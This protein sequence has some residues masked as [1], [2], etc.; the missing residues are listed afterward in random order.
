MVAK[1]WCFLLI[2]TDDTLGYT[3]G[4]PM[5]KKCSCPRNSKV[6]PEYL[7]DIHRTGELRYC[8][9]IVLWFAIPLTLIHKK[10]I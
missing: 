3:N 4:H 9:Q 7:I 5:I 1:Y 2:K 8:F 10:N 6:L